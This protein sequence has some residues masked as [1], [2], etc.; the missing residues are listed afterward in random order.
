MGSKVKDKEHISKET[1][2]SGTEQNKASLLSRK[3]LAP[4]LVTAISLSPLAST[5]QTLAKVDNDN[6]P[7][8]KEI[9]YSPRIENPD[10]LNLVQITPP[11]TGKKMPVAV[12]M[13]AVNKKPEMS[14]T[15][16]TGPSTGPKIIGEKYF[17]VEVKG[18]SIYLSNITFD[19]VKGRFELKESIE[20]KK[21]FELK[22]IIYA[23]IANQGKGAYLIFDDAILQVIPSYKIE[24]LIFSTT[25]SFD[26]T[27]IFIHDKAIFLVENGAILASTSSTL[28]YITSK[29]AVS[30]TYKEL[31]GS[32]ALDLIKP[33]FKQGENENVIY[34]RDKSI[35]GFNGEKYAIKIN[36]KDLTYEVVDDPEIMGMKK[37]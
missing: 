11:D 8:P 30:I 7:N 13:Y 26:S 9:S 22:Q 18:D 23:D 19:G 14:D 12:N 37:D 34:L 31:F 16:G 1:G 33:Y 28:L 20:L 35:V 4:V 5:A 21:G 15:M 3:L 24:G 2:T 36:I 29:K 10:S 27:K 32:S 25:H 6:A 17:D